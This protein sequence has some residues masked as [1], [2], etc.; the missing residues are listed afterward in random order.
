[1][2]KEN[3]RNG[4]DP[5]LRYHPKLGQSR[6]ASPLWRPCISNG[7]NQSAAAA[8]GN[9]GG[10]GGGA[11][12]H[13]Y[14]GTDEERAVFL[15]NCSNVTAHEQSQ[16]FAEPF[17]LRRRLTTSEARAEA[18]EE[19]CSAAK[20]AAAE[21]AAEAR[22]L[23]ER[24]EAA[25]AENEELRRRLESAR[26]EVLAAAAAAAGAAAG[27]GVSMSGAC[28]GGRDGVTGDDDEKENGD[29]APWRSEHREVI[30]AIDNKENGEVA[31][32]RSTRRK[33]LDARHEEDIDE[34]PRRSKR[35]KVLDANAPS[36]WRDDTYI[37]S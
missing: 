9:G 3:E 23:R 31:P 22:V 26:V 10:G 24:A 5:A 20:A 33:V 6:D 25:E 19:A 14:I 2:S 4:T 36:T 27:A 1:M 13:E 17:F 11:Y 35:G 18:A 34:A 8:S 29:V 21:I 15:E 7:N 16:T 12:C 28:G 30:D 32:Q 37:Y